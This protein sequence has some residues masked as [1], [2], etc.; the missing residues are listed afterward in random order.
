MGYNLT[1]D[2]VRENWT[3]D[4]GSP[5]AFDEWRIKHDAELTE[6][7]RAETLAEAAVA[8]KGYTRFARNTIE[9]AEDAVYAATPPTERKD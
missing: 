6:K 4:N 8:V 1:T 3:Q 2:D 9:F 7:V 5:D